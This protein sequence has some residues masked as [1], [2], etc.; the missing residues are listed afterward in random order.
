ML[1][2]LRA[3]MKFSVFALVLA[4][5]VG[6]LVTMLLSPQN[7]ENLLSSRYE[8]SFANEESSASIGSGQKMTESVCQQ[9]YILLSTQRSGSTW[10]SKLLDMQDTIALGR[11]LGGP[12][13]TETELMLAAFQ[14]WRKVRQ[15]E[16]LK[17]EEYQQTLDTI[18]EGLCRENPTVS[19]GFKLMYDQIPRRFIWEDSNE[20]ESY[21][22]ENNI[23]VLHL[24]REAHILKLASDYSN[25]VQKPTYH[26]TNASK[27][28][29]LRKTPKMPWDGKT[30]KK[31]LKQEKLAQVWQQ[32]FHFMA[33]VPYHY[34]SYE[35]LLNAHDRH[36]YLSQAIDFL[37]PT[38]VE[39]NESGHITSMSTMGHT[40][41]WDADP[42]LQLHESKCSDRIQNYD[43]F[44]KHPDLQGSRTIAACDLIDKN[45]P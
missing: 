21:V 12:M 26:T 41:R 42:L 6:S 1:D 15:W 40:L 24:V 14:Q 27:A 44:R 17:W 5:T 35:N 23:S 13:G 43:E 30:I 10:V 18:F 36:H 8:I 38:L 39:K 32:K 11:D 45:V 28:L 22:Q 29:A 4:F 7:P 9:K 34:L 37:T 16:T 31:V 33:S 20:F 25:K 2:L 19:I 3:T